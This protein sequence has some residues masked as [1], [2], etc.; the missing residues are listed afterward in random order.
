[1]AV[2]A[3]DLQQVVGVA[4]PWV[5]LD[6][7]KRMR[8]CGRDATKVGRLNEVGVVTSDILSRTAWCIPFCR[9]F[10]FQVPGS[11]MCSRAHWWRIKKHAQGPGGGAMRPTRCESTA[12]RC[13]DVQSVL[14]PTE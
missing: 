3:D 8:A 1:M 4:P 9:H 14:M 12:E 6:I 11:R 7:Y 13:H 2:P 10:A 5:P